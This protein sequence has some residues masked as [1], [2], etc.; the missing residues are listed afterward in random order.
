MDIF[1]L[2][3]AWNPLH[4]LLVIAILLFVCLKIY[5]P[6]T[7]RPWLYLAKQKDCEP[8]RHNNT[9]TEKVGTKVAGDDLERMMGLELLQQHSYH[10]KLEI[11]NITPNLVYSFKISLPVSSHGRILDRTLPV[12][13]ENKALCNDRDCINHRALVMCQEC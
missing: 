7:L 2:L 3:P 12:T 1:S 9:F 8:G 10:L 4:L 5:S 11:T 6:S 13:S